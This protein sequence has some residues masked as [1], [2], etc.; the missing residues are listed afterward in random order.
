MKNLINILPIFLAIL[1]SCNSFDDGIAKQDGQQ[2]IIRAYNDSTRV[3]FNGSSSCWESGD[4]LNV[5]IDGLDDV[6]QFNY[7]SENEFICNSLALPSTSNNLY[8]FSGVNPNNINI[9]NKTALVKLGATIQTQNTQNPTAHISEYDILYG[10]ALGVSDDDIAISMNHTISI[11]K[12]NISNSLQ[13]VQNIKSVTVTTPEN[14]MITGDYNISPDG[15]NKLSIVSGSGSNNVTV[16]FDEI[17]L[18]G[19]NSSSFTAWLAVAPFKLSQGDNLTIDITTSDN[20]IYRC[21]KIISNQAGKS[22]NAGSIMSTSIVLGDNATTETSLPATIDYTL[23]MASLA[24]AGFPTSQNSIEKEGEYT[25][26]GYTFKF[27][28][29]TNYYLYSSKIYFK[30]NGKIKNDSPVMIELPQKSGYKLNSVTLASNDATRDRNYT[31]TI[32]YYKDGILK[33][34]GKD[35]MSATTKEFDL[36]GIDMPANTAYY[37]WIGNMNGGNQG[38]AVLTN[39]SLHYKKL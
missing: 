38:V 12:I 37:I 27:N 6:Y 16:Q 17:E 11:L 14:I 10:A 26:D 9:S 4:I 24:T 25:V 29:P 1:T 23:D 5:A 18:R 22:F 28:S 36:S 39:L 34:V 30:G 3:S 7:T 32:A 35:Y 13:E 19:G 31:Y 8:A 15:N 2:V 33:D 20:T 21:K